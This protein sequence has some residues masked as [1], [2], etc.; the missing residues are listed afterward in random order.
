VTEIQKSRN[1]LHFHALLRGVGEEQCQYWQH[2]WFKIG[3]LADIKK[4]D[5][6]QKAAYYLAKN[7]TDDWSNIR[8]SKGFKEICKFRQYEK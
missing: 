1:A 5:S 8:L 2:E 7:V 6:E 3:G 4:Y